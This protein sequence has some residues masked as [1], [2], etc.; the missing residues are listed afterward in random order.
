MPPK[1]FLGSKTLSGRARE[2]TQFLEALKLYESRQYKKS[3]KILET[4]LKK[5][6]T[7][8]DALALKGL[9]LLSMGEK[10]EADNYIKNAISKIQG[11]GASAICCHVLGIY[12]RSSKNYPEAVKWF[13]TSLNNGSTNQQIYR[14]LA[15]LQSQIGDF[16]GAL[17]SRRTYWEAF[18]GY[19]ANWTSLAIAQDINGERQ[20]AVNTLSQF[21]KL[22]EGK[23]GEAELYEHSECLMYKNDIMFRA[24]GDNEEKLQNVLRHLTDI[25]ANVY[26]KY[27]ILERKAAIYL[28]LSDAKQASKHYRMLLQR[29]PDNFE[30]YKLLEKSL[31]VQSDVTKRE[32]LYENLQKFYPR[33][34]PPKFIPLTFITDK[35]KLETKFKEYVLPLLK[36]GVPA[37][38]ANVKPLYKKKFSL[39]PAISEKV[40]SEFYSSLNPF[41]DPISY[42]WTSYYLS[43]HY[44]FLKDFSQAE[45]FIDKALESTPTL[46]ELYIMKGRV[47]KAMAKLD[48]AADIL[49][50]GRKLDLQDRFINTKTVKYLLRANKIDKAVEIVSLFTKNDDSINGV[51]DLHLVEASWFITEQAEAYNR[52]FIESQK[53]LH[54]ILEEVKNSGVK[55]TELDSKLRELKHLKWNVEKFQGLSLKRFQAI[56]KIYRQFED[57][58][59]DF[60]SYCMRKGTPKAYLEMLSWG[61]TIYQSPMYIRAMKGAAGILFQLHDK[62]STP[63]RVLQETFDIVMK[64]NSK[65]SKKINS[66][67]NKQR[68]EEK[69]AVL[70]YAESEDDD[71]FGQRLVS[72]KKPLQEFWIEFYAK[73]SNQVSE[74]KRDYP[75]EFEYQYRMGK[76]ALCLGAYSKYAG[77][78]GEN[79]GFA[80]AMA[81]VLLLATRECTPFEIIAK[82]VAYKGCESIKSLPLA[83]RDNEEFDWA[84]FFSQHFKKDLPSLLFLYH[85]VSGHRP[86]FKNLIFEKISNSRPQLQM[87]IL[88]YQL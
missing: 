70:A 55:D 73:Y 60:H 19:R 51:K 45:F 79:S 52:L 5:D 25:E 44:L 88:Q 27:A 71:I 10:Q 62:I 37:T 15:T 67:L 26:D 75:L 30:Y 54:D 4:I 69:K 38:F 77:F 56:A 82:K 33:C 58:Q 42:V 87:Q 66:S 50:E 18:L 29:N 47:L 2:H 86:A 9:D 49:E 16:K 85:N 35:S 57:D 20:Q 41:E 17:A 83:E 59:L 28:K 13:Q 34:D 84:A 76:L 46:V 39:V 32:I 1:R 8:V 11:I 64:E 6:S 74:E 81:I 14:D 72:T 22:V 21:E 68:E 7:N 61:K 63:N 3:V 40:V 78:H 31:G 43:Q 48:A 80:G 65:K 24:A 53:K 36:R 23:L 12:M